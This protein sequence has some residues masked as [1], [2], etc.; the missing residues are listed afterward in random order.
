MVQQQGHPVALQWPT[1]FETPGEAAKAIVA[2][3]P[4]QA[5]A[6]VVFTAFNS[7]MLDGPGKMQP[8][9]FLPPFC[10]WL[11]SRGIASHFAVTPQTLA[12]LAGPR[13]IVIHIYR[14]VGCDIVTPEIEDAQKDSLVFNAPRTG[15]TIADK[16][17]TH[18]LF[19]QHGLPMPDLADGG[20]GIVFSNSAKDSGAAVQLMPGGTALDPSR[21][22]TRFIDTRV[23]LR[24]KSYFTTVRLL[25]IGRHIAHAYV[26]AGGASTDSSPSVH[27]ADTPLEPE[28]IER[29]QQA[30]VAPRAE[31]LSALAS[32]LGL[33]LGPGFYAHDLLIERGTGNIYICESGFK[34]HDWSYGNRIHPIA[35]DLPSHRFMLTPDY[36]VRAARLFLA[37]CRD[38]GF[39]F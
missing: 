30:L 6:C 5:T 34:F 20:E 26:R 9:V 22:N 29:L 1:R 7:A 32:R 39:S 31:A 2:A 37:A 12:R 33:L 38:S 19:T 24:G 16:M 14:E 13:T 28:L 4:T 23:V 3:N 27:A 10:A 15:R 35:Q 36:A 11:A 8:A 18:R 17:A 25:C 21:Y